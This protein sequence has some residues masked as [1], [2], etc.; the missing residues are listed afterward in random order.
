MQQTGN[1]WSKKLS[2]TSNLTH[3]PHGGLEPYSTKLNGF[4]DNADRMHRNMTAATH[5]LQNTRN[6]TISK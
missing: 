5:D 4:K 1:Q 6:F 2:Y 3:S